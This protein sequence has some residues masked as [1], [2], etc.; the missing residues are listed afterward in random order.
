MLENNLP[1][2]RYECYQFQTNTSPI[3]E[4]LQGAGT[5]IMHNNANRTGTT[6]DAYLQA[7]HSSAGTKSALLQW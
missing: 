2:V 3:K 5:T 1:N 4:L 6:G 7:L